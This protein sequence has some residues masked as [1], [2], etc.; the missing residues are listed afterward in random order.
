MQSHMNLKIKFRESF[1]PFAPM[2]LIEDADKYFDLKQESPY[3]LLLYHVL[4]ELRFEMKNKSLFGIELIK[5]K[6]ST[7]PAI[8][9][10]DYSARLQTIDKIRNPFMW[11]VISKFKQITGC[12]VI[13]NTSFNVRGEPIVNS[14]IDIYRCFMATEIDCLVI[15]NRFFEREKQENRP[16]NQKERQKWLRRFKLD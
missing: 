8:T 15:G 16:L 5:E 6:R 11:D 1:R 12:S 3:M 2:V 7:V 14:I 9:H 4:P 13:I 10:V